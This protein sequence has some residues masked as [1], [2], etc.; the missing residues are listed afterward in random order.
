[1]FLITRESI[2][3]INLRQAYL[4]QPTYSRKLSSR[5]VLFRAV[6]DEYLNEARLRRI[7][8]PH[9]VRIWF[10]TDTKNLQRMVD[11]LEQIATHLEDAETQLIRTANAA[12]LKSLKKGLAPEH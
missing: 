7:L 12:R 11:G 8:G 9:V 4:M 6:P 1:M 3:F 10:P 2:F 5:T